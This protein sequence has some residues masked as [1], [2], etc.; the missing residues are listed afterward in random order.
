ME[1]TMLFWLLP[2]GFLC[3]LLLRT[4]GKKG[5][6]EAQKNTSGRFKYLVYLVMVV[7]VSA[8]VILAIT[9]SKEPLPRLMPDDF[10]AMILKGNDYQAGILNQKKFKFIN[11]HYFFGKNVS[12]S[13]FGP[14]TSSDNV[15]EYILLADNHIE[16]V[17]KDKDKY[18]RFLE[19]LNQG[20]ASGI[21]KEDFINS[22]DVM[23]KNQTC[24]Q[25]KNCAF[26][27]YG[28]VQDNFG[29]TLW[30]FPYSFLKHKDSVKNTETKIACILSL[31]DIRFNEDKQF[32][33]SFIRFKAK[34]GNTYEFIGKYSIS[35][36]EGVVEI[37]E[38]SLKVISGN[39]KG[40]FSLSDDCNVLNI[41]L[42]KK[43]MYSTSDIIFEAI[44]V[45]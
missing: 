2:I 31:N 12:P 26:V 34:Q 42:T 29:Y 5:K 21:R 23:G 18:D 35:E 44:R 37:T 19:N 14:T 6:T 15:H 20:G 28:F 22:D 36:V 4:L 13:L 25:L 16:Y 30:T 32:S 17:I 40:N 43:N 38:N 8:I 27:D 7:A 24:Y 39:C 45:E 11:K 10:E 1:L 33:N 9:S 3:L 41:N